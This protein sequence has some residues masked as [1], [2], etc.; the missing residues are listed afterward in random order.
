V[1]L[2]AVRF[3][4][5]AHNPTMDNAI[6]LTRRLYADWERGDYATTWWVHPEID[7]RVSD[8]LGR[9]GRGA[10]SLAAGWGDILATTDNLSA[11][12]EGIEEIDEGVFAL[13]RFRGVGKT[14][15]VPYD[16]LPAA[17]LHVWKDG[18]VV[19]LVMW[20]NRETAL[21]E[22]GLKKRSFGR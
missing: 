8:A 17:S 6:E 11:S 7:W 3:A 20:T 22:L 14:S 2:T 19:K 13:T 4:Q 16:A 15:G 5:T 9:A 18:L 10:A 12:I 1:N 21:E